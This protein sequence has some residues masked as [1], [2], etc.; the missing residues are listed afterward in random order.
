MQ[1]HFHNNYSTLQKKVDPACL[2]SEYGGYLG[3]LLELGT[4]KDVIKPSYNLFECLDKL[5]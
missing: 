1:L 4:A 3:P 5:K 2:P